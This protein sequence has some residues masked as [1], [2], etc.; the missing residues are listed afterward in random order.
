[1][2]ISSTDSID[3]M[4]VVKNLADFPRNSGNLLERVVFNHRRL[5]LLLCLLITLV[6]GFFAA[7][8]S[9]NASFE[10][11]IPVNH[12]YV[13]NYLKYKSDLRGMGNTLRVVVETPMAM[14]SMHA[15]STT[16]A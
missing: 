2:A 15:T 5:M 7:G 9:L 1:M 3:H 14:C 6:M 10:K 11:M 13:Q 4:P 8:I 16:C 12:P